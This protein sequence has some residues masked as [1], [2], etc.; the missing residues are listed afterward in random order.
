MEARSNR[1][2]ASLR[3]PRPACAKKQPDDIHQVVVQQDFAVAGPRTRS[4][5]LW[6]RCPS[7]IPEPFQR[8]NR[9]L[10]AS[11]LWR[12]CGG[13]RPGISRRR[14]T[15]RSRLSGFPVPARFGRPQSPVPVSA[16]FSQFSPLV[17]IDHFYSALP[18]FEERSESGFWGRN[19][20]R[21]DGLVRFSRSDLT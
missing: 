14:N 9:L 11:S 17:K 8:E 10:A 20:I 6:R 16:R 12:F 4:G 3:S 1:K 7:R 15:Q 5:S 19:F 21:H 2:I 13:P 18:P